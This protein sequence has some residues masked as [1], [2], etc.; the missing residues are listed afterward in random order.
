MEVITG[1]AQFTVNPGGPAHRAA[2]KCVHFK[3]IVHSRLHCFESGGDSKQG[4]DKCWSGVSTGKLQTGWSCIVRARGTGCVLTVCHIAV[5]NLV[6]G[7]AYRGRLSMCRE[8]SCRAWATNSAENVLEQTPTADAAA[9]SIQK[10]LLQS[11][12]VVMC[13]SKKP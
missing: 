1:T 11:K 8:S 13:V 3:T 7:L 9:H 10:A 2:I 12:T 4:A 6:R 5:H